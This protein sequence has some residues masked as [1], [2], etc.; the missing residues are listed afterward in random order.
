MAR[1]E[2][3]IDE[4]IIPLD[5]VYSHGSRIIAFRLTLDAVR[6]ERGMVVG[7][8]IDCTVQPVHALSCGVNRKRH[9]YTCN[10]G[11]QEMFDKLVNEA[12]EAGK[13]N[14]TTRNEIKKVTT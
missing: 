4:E 13:A 8:Y 6:N 9:H 7:P 11:A 5:P 12:G 2:L 3:C 1:I 14:E 10:C